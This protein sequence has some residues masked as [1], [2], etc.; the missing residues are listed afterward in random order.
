MKIR[1]VISLAALAICMAAAAAPARASA[2]LADPPGTA[3]ADE[4]P[5]F[6]QFA[7]RNNCDFHQWAWQMFLADG[8][9]PVAGG[10]LSF[11]GPGRC[12]AR[13]ARKGHHPDAGVRLTSS[14]L[15]EYLRAGLTASWSIKGPHRHYS[16]TSTTC[17]AV[18]D[19]QQ[20]PRSRACAVDPNLPLPVGTLSLKAWRSSVRT[21]GRRLH[22]QGDVN[23]LV[24]KAGFYRSSRTEEASRWRWSAS[25]SRNFSRITPR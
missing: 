1:S 9:T 25:T 22:P 3:F 14:N 7:T 15:D 13:P 24:K 23:P 21:I 5:G 18:R 10:F 4:P 11:A 8:R 6:G 19:R 20:A 16:S 17:S 2:C 12:A